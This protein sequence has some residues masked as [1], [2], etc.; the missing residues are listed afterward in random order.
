MDKAQQVQHWSMLDLPLTGKIARVVLMRT[1]KILALVGVL[2]LASPSFA[3]ATVTG[4][5]AS[6][7]AS[8]SLPTLARGERSLSLLLVGAHLNSCS[9]DV[10]PSIPNFP[11]RLKRCNGEHTLQITL[12]VNGALVDAKFTVTVSGVA[13]KSPKAVRI[14]L[15]QHPEYRVQIYGDSIAH[16]FAPSFAADLE[17]T[18]A[19]Q[20]KINTFPGASLCDALPIATIDAP[21]FQPDIVVVVY[22]GT[23]FTPCT[24]TAANGSYGS[25]KFF[26][27]YTAN[28][29]SLA[30]TFRAVHS[31]AVLFDAGPTPPNVNPAHNGIIA[32]YDTA[33]NKLA[34]LAQ[35]I[36]P[37]VSVEGPGG[38]WV[39]NLPCLVVEITQ[40]H[41]TGPIVDAVQQNPVRSMAG[42]L[43]HL[44]TSAFDPSDWSPGCPGYS[45]GMLR[46]A[47]TVAAQIMS[48]WG[49]SPLPAYAS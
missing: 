36:D 39:A 22:V 45:S 19:I 21:V 46:Y 35:R 29:V 15:V 49:F 17:A 33:V 12:P 27:N 32:A 10:K 11:R 13:P 8:T 40:G 14:K 20:V 6:L 4:P 38:S 5:K 2:V 16:Q 18:G 25:P 43:F 7:S 28:A 34:G 37:G 24:Q 44:C 47:A 3:G 42:D 26:R 1:W 31:S 48:N 23:G 41:C 9:V 30:K